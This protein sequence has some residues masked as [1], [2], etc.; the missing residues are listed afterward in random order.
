MEKIRCHIHVNSKLAR[1][2]ALVMGVKGVAMVLGRTIHLYGASRV[3]FLSNTAWLRHE[4]CHL[5]QYRQYGLIGFLSRYLY[6]CARKGYYNNR[7]EVAAR[8]AEA[9]PGILDEIEII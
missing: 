7:L 6:E 3:E 9:D 5:K 2:A 1:I 4:A 8:K